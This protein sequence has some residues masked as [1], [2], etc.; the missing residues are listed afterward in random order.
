VGEQRYHAVVSGFSGKELHE[1][2]DFTVA[3]AYLREA[4]MRAK[5]LGEATPPTY[6]GAYLARLLAQTV[7]VNRLDEAEQIAR[8]IIGS[9]NA[10]LI[11]EAR[12]VLAEI[13]RRRGDLTDAEREA[14]AACEAVRPFPSFGWGVIALHARI[15][16]GQE[17]AED[18]LAVAEA[19]VREIER[20]G[21]EGSGE[22]DLRLSLAEALHAV[23]RTD[24]AR[25]TLADVLPRLKKRLDDIPEA[26]ARERYLTEVPANARIV[27]LAKEWLDL[28]VRA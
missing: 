10:P 4:V 22:I 1:L 25:E 13:M 14:R 11:G 23:G 2:G 7:P 16:L 6:A 15:L 20:L 26:A 8:D 28:E 17:R 5:R 21:L 27:A 18:A 9:N 12:G 3:E 19:G 24:A